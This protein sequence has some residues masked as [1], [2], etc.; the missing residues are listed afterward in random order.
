MQ[1]YNTYLWTGVWLAVVPFLGVPG[2]LKQ[3]LTVL[4]GFFL[5]IYSVIAYRY[6]RVREDEALAET[7]EEDSFSEESISAV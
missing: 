2:S 5:I 6:N 7:E 1:K 3:T 4:T